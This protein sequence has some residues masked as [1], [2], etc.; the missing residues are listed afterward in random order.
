MSDNFEEGCGCLVF[1]LILLVVGYVAKIVV[2]WLLSLG[3]IGI[4]ILGFLFLSLFR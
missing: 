3:I 1:L 2:L 4:I